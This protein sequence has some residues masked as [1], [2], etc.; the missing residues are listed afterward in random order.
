MRTSKAAL[1]AGGSRNS[2]RRRGG[3]SLSRLAAPSR[4]SRLTLKI[5]NLPAGPLS[6]RCALDGVPTC[7]FSLLC[8][9]FALYLFTNLLCRRLFALAP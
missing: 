9:A 7:C 5:L 8:E 6:D 3:F 1:S 2:F 4:F